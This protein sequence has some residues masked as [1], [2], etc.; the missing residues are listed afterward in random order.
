MKVLYKQYFGLKIRKLLGYKTFRLEMGTIC[1]KDY[2][3]TVGGEYQYSEGGLLE[4][5]IIEDILFKNFFLELIVWFMDQK[6]YVTC[7]YRMVDCGYPGMWRIWDKNHY[8]I[9]EWRSEHN[10]PVDQKLLDSIRIIYLP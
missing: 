1:T 6:R 10:C 3:I 7:T 8:D 2:I 5:V 9:D 4:Q